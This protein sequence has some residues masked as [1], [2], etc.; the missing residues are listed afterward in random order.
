[1]APSWKRPPALIRLQTLRLPA[2]R[3]KAWRMVGLGRLE[4]PT[5]R[6]SSARSNQLSYKP[7]AKSSANTAQFLQL[8]DRSDS[9]EPPRSAF[10]RPPQGGR[11]KTASHRI[12]PAGPS[13]DKT[14]SDANSS[15]KKEKRRRRS[16]ANEPRGVLVF[17]GIEEAK[18]LRRSLNDHP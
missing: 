10:A 9:E 8:R 14:Q 5:S 16:P 1:M 12:A 3:P 15:G 7:K 17:K 2:D 4:L 18:G 6:L 11:T 13:T